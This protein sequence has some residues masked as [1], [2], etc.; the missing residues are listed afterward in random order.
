ML[1]RAR[2]HLPARPCQVIQRGNH[3]EAYAC[4]LYQNQDNLT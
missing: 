2:M 3:R 1:R 4:L